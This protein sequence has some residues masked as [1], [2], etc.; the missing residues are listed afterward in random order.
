MEHFFGESEVLLL[1]DGREGLED[2]RKVR[3]LFRPVDQ[4]L[5]L[6]IDAR[7]STHVTLLIK[8]ETAQ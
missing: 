3:K 8:L 1:V 2:V 4:L 5:D 7:N 6:D